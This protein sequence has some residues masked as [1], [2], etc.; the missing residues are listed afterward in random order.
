MADVKITNV[1]TES[2]WIAWQPVN[3]SLQ[4]VSGYR[5]SVKSEDSMKPSIIN[6][7]TSSHLNVTGLQAHTDYSVTVSVL[8]IDRQSAVAQSEPL[9]FQTELGM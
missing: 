3:S 4:L 7:T 2:A 6:D 5:I 8:T 1:S 9:R